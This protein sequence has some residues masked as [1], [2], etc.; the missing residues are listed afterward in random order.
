MFR[1]YVRK[2]IVRVHS[3]EVL[4]RAEAT[5]EIYHTVRRWLLLKE[6]FMHAV[7]LGMELQ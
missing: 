7:S 2:L 4:P 3:V 5:R 1:V 6:K